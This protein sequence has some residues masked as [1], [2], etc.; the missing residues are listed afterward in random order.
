MKVVFAA[1]ARINF[2]NQIDY[3]IAQGATKAAKRLRLRVHTFLT[4]F[5]IVHPRTG[6]YLAERDLWET[7][8]PRTKMIIWYRFTADVLAV[9]DVWHSSQDRQSAP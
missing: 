3:L 9:I 7:N 8:I 2:D 1:R 5:L 6:A 4:S